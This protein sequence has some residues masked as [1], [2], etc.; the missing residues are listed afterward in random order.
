MLTMY[1]FL[2]NSMLTT[3]R[4]TNSSFLLVG[5]RAGFDKTF[6][7]QNF[8]NNGVW[9]G[10]EG[11]NGFFETVKND[12]S[13]KYFIRKNRFKSDRKK[14]DFKRLENPVKHIHRIILRS[15]VF[16]YSFKYDTISTQKFVDD[17]PSPYF[18]PDI[19]CL[20]AYI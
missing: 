5:S 20:V 18:G 17:F 7:N 16:H 13:M 8:L 6:Q 9:G 1:F 4:Q 12:N 10:R 15:F 2:L 3:I 14:T 11:E 19:L